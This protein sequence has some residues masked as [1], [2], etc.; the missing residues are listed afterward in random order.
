[1]TIEYGLSDDGFVPKRLPEIKT[2]IEAQL[3]TVFGAINKSPESVFGQIIGV[4]SKPLA[5]L[6]EQLE[7]VYFSQYPDT[8]EGI[9][10]D[11][12]ARLTGITRRPAT[13]SQGIA[14]LRGD[15][16][17][18]IPQT[19]Q[20]QTDVTKYVFQ[21]T[22]DVIIQKA[23]IAAIYINVEEAQDGV[24]Y[25]IEVDSVE[26]S[27]TAPGGST[28]ASIATLL[29][30]KLIAE[31]PAILDSLDL[32]NGALYLT[33]KAG[34]F[35][36]EVVARNLGGDIDGLIFWCTPA[37]IQALEKGNLPAPAGALVEIVTPVT[38]MD[39]V[40]NFLA[41]EP[42]RDIETDAEY[43]LRR[44]QSLAVAGAATVEAIRAR[45]LDPVRGVADVLDAFVFENDTD[46][47]VEGRD[48]H[49]IEVVVSGGDEQDIADFL[50]LVKAGGIKTVG[51][52]PKTVTD[53]MGVEHIISFSR[54]LE[55][56]VWI[57]IGVHT[58]SEEGTFP[59]DGEEQIKEKLLEYGETV[60]IGTDLIF[61][62][63]YPPVFQV[64]GISSV[65]IYT[66]M[67]NLDVS[68]PLGT[69]DLAAL[70]TYFETLKSVLNIGDTFLVETTQDTTDAALAAAKGSAPAQYDVFEITNVVAPAVSYVGNVD[71]A[72]PAPFPAYGQV[73]IP[74]DGTEKP[75]F[76]AAKMVVTVL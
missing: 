47:V 36:I 69:A 43:R 66:A 50:W 32:G 75:V 55:R 21:T 35:S 23:A 24:E 42:G 33:E 15:A 30:N 54:P 20:F 9:S 18:T 5:D 40:N 60:S 51:Q 67:P 26:H 37:A 68:V 61:Q 16:G 3:E 19:T 70:F 8:A 58:Y 48:P 72:F 12:A 64:P 27:V 57:R 34:S 39:A 65:D 22:A 25:V 2:D 59:D 74:V 52:I 14:A 29:H 73:N 56:N 46:A 13:Y 76:S 53:S 49:S 62:R 4:L 6:W 71:Q 11:Y 10:L 1:M 28:K 38:G 44:S 45:I 63:L 17:T 7:H 41:V 31:C